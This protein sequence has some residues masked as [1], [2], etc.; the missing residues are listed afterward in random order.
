MVSAGVVR[1]IIAIVLSLEPACSVWIAVV[2]IS[3]TRVLSKAL[4]LS[5]LAT[6]KEVNVRVNFGVLAYFLGSF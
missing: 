4:D 6:W 3:V 1:A 2:I 5:F